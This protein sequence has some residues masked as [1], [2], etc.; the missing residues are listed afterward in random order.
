L[1]GAAGTVWSGAAE[2]FRALSILERSDNFARG[3]I[4]LEDVVY[5]LSLIT[6]TLFIATR[7]LE[8]RRYS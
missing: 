1:I 8:T 5:Y 3:V 7:I 2:V 4:N 6:G